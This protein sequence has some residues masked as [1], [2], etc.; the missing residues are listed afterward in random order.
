MGALT[1]GWGLS[2]T[3]PC[4]WIPFP[5]LGLPGWASEGEDVPSPAEV[6][7]QGGV[8]LKGSGR[9]LKGWNWEE[10]RVGL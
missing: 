5:L 4:H 7:A 10:R 9:F 1:S 2:V 8:V 6:N 3:V